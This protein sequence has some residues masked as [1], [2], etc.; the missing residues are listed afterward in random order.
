MSLCAKKKLLLPAYLLAFLA[1]LGFLLWKCR[2]GYANM[3]EAFYLTIP[4]RLCRGDCLIVHEWHLSQLSGFLLWPAMWF[5]QLLFRDTEGILLR[6]RLL[7]TFAWA[8]GALFLYARLRRFSRAG[9]ML[10]SL[11]FLLYAPFGI[12]ALSYNSMGILLLLSSCTLAASAE[13]RRRGEYALAGLLFAGSVLCCPYLL[14]AYLLFTA[15]SVAL[16]LRGRG[17]LLRCWLPFTLG[18]AVLLL[19]FCAALLR[20]ASPEALL[21]ALP[22]LFRDPEHESMPLVQQSGAYLL[23][24]VRES[25]L[26]PFAAAALVLISL[27]SRWRKAPAWGLAALCLPCL[28]M[29][30]E[31]LLR[32]PYLNFFM[33]PLNLFAPY[34]A[35]HSQDRGVRLPFLTIWLPGALYTYCISLSSNQGFYAISSASTVMTVASVV[36]LLRFVQTLGAYDVRRLSR[37]AALVGTALVLLVQFYGEARLRY[38]TVFWEPGMREQTALAESGPERGILMSPE[39]LDSYLEGERDA[40]LIRSRPELQKLLFLSERT[41]LYLSTQREI[42]A[43]SAWLSKVNETSLERLERYY[44]LCPEK[45]PDAI[46]IEP[47]FASYTARV[48]AWGY[49]AETLD[50]GAYLLTKGA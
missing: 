19:L 5:D 36:M 16:R 13:G 12:M 11:V 47:E 31:C 37:R 40:A 50:S 7:F 34:C 20:R 2:Y 43:F 39:R 6:F 23:A 24:I 8:A 33:F 32:T 41:H 14:L 15:L 25:P 27:L 3:D 21:R 44:A 9:A 22:E 18:C 38:N 26:I 29:Q 28:L 46:Y 1:A 4:Y 42:A 45:L 17:G 30:A 48:E 49:C 35:L 10:G